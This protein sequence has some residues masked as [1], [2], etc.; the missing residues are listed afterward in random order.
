MKLGRDDF[1]RLKLKKVASYDQECQDGKIG[2]DFRPLCTMSKTSNST[3]MSPKDHRIPDKVI[4]KCFVN[5]LK[6]ELFPEEMYS[7]SFE[8]LDDVV[9]DAR[10][11][12]PTYRDILEFSDRVNK[13][14]PKRSLP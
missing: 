12:L 3:L 14:E 1:V 10:K 6:P 13:S 7:R 5:G 9:H 8:N 4:V 11:K 2:F